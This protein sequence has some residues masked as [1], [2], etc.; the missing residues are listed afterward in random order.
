MLLNSSSILLCFTLLIGM[1]ESSTAVIDCTGKIG[2]RHTEQFWKCNRGGSME[3]KQIIR[4]CSA[5]TDHGEALEGTNYYDENG[6]LRVVGEG[7]DCKSKCTSRR[8]TSGSETHNSETE[9][10]A[11]SGSAWSVSRPSRSA[12]GLISKLFSSTK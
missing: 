11:E 6:A 10:C 7:W 9:S 3:C 2:T 1:T 8:E 4:D 12:P 5:C